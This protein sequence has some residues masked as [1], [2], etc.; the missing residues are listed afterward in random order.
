MLVSVSVV[1][2]SVPRVLGVVGDAA[3]VLVSV[4]VVDDTVVLVEV[5]VDASV[6]E[7][8]LVAVVVK[9]GTQLSGLR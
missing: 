9:V 7:T 6:E 3:G 4:S 1:L 2:V 8:V 5:A